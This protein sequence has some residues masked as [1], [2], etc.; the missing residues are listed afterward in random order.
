DS[1]RSDIKISPIW[2]ETKEFA[3]NFLRLHSYN[4][5]Q[6]DMVTG[7]FNSEYFWDIIR[8]KSQDKAYENLTLIR[9][10]NCPDISLVAS[11]LKSNL[12]R[13]FGEDFKIYR[14]YDS[15]FGFFLAENE[16][17][18]FQSIVSEILSELN[19]H[20]SG[21]HFSVGAADK[22]LTY[23]SSQRWFQKAE[24]ALEESALSGHNHYKQFSLK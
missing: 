19:Q 1:P 9:F 18:Q 8:L 3:K 11:V 7:L 10:F 21:I 17:P 16:N 2:N 20:D 22:N 15:T 6:K 4:F 12:S 23:S 24:N 5:S 13:L 14:L